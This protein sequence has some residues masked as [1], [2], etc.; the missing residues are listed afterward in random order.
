[1]QK[2]H[3]GRPRALAI[4]TRSWVLDFR[5]DEAAVQIPWS[6]FRFHCGTHRGWL[7]LDHPSLCAL[8]REPHAELLSDAL[9]Y[10]V[11]ADALHE[12]VEQIER[13]TRLHFEWQPLP[14]GVNQRGAMRPTALSLERCISV[15]ASSRDAPSTIHALLQF[16]EASALELLTRIPS[17]ES[18]SQPVPAAGARDRLDRIPLQVTFVLGS[19]SLNVAEL[20]EIRRGDI[21]GIERWRGSGTAMQVR[22]V[23]GGDR[24]FA[25]TAAAENT[26]IKVQQMEPLRMQETG[27]RPTSNGTELPKQA[28]DRLDA[29]EVVLHFEI[30]EHSVALGDLKNIRPGYVFELGQPLNRSIVRISAHGN[31]LGRGYLVAIGDRL[32]LRVSEFAP[33]DL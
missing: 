11:L 1:M 10:I 25:I 9:R 2:L 4:G 32:G 13:S 20:R 6:F 28:I 5:Y 26:Q 23:V 33:G 29:L 3:G 22:A 7:G 30:A 31:M 24:G 15:R 27:S 21:I 19:T 18:A 8:L 16:D 14:A 17:E 12:L